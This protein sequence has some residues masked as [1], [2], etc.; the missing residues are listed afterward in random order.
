[1]QSVHIILYSPAAVCALLRWSDQY[2]IR[3]GMD[4]CM[5]SCFACN[6]LDELR[7]TD[8]LNIADAVLGHLPHA[9]NTHSHELFYVILCDI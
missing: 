3:A 1:M 2:Y 6:Q 9:L 4:G 8:I 7:K 5:A